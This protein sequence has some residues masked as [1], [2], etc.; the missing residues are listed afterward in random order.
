M[1]RWMLAIV[2][3]VAACASEPEPAPVPELACGA[4]GSILQ[5]YRP[6]E[7]AEVAGCT[8]LLGGLRFGDTDLTTIVG[9][10]HVHTVADSVNFFRNME[11]VEIDA[12][13]RLTTVG[14]DLLVHH[15][16]ALPG[17]RF[18]RLQQVGGTLLVSSNNVLESLAGLGELREVGALRIIGNPQL[19]TLAHLPDLVID[20]DLVIE[21]N[22]ALPRADAQA[23]AARCVVAGT[24]TIAD[25]AP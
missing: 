3:G 14:G 4:A 5:P 9:L 15:D 18:L 16:S 21:E 11:L 24:V 19:R 8:S 25:N 23:F 22:A 12:L 13:N 17:F 7:F 2:I 1:A 6:E 20:G 10:R